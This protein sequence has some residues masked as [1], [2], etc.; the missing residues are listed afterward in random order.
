MSEWQPIETAPKDGTEILLTGTLEFDAS[1]Y[2][3]HIAC[4]MRAS[5]PPVVIGSYLRSSGFRN[6]VDVETS[7]TRRVQIREGYAYEGWD[8]DWLTPTHWMPLP[9]PPV[10]TPSQ[11]A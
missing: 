10:N 4:E 1:D 11:S 3:D 9:K 7:D 6:W 5:M 8:P 2:P